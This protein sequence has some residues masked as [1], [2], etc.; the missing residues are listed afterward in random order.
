MIAFSMAQL[1]PFWRSRS[2]VS[3]QLFYYLSLFSMMSGDFDTF[4]SVAYGTPFLP[5]PPPLNHFGA[6]FTPSLFMSDPM[7]S[8]R[9]D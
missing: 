7:S 2:Y 4:S 1:L 8:Q 5:A 3:C 9:P 6:P